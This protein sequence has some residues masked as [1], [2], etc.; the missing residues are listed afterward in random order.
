MFLIKKWKI[1]LV[2]LLDMVKMIKFTQHLG[3]LSFKIPKDAFWNSRFIYET[4]CYYLKTV[5]LCGLHQMLIIKLLCLK[6]LIQLNNNNW[7]GQW[8]SYECHPPIIINITDG[9]PTDAGDGFELLI[10][11][12]DE[13]KNINTVYGNTM[14]FVVILIK[15][16]LIQYYFL[17]IYKILRSLCKSYVWYFSGLMPKMLEQTE[18]VII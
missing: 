7:L 16:H 8:K 14:I 10:E 12:A 15:V 11:S 13:I 18:K 9:I 6:L 5:I 1:D 4:L 17:V 3:P 2:G